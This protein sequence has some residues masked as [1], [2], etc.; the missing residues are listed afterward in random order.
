MIWIHFVVGDPFLHS[1]SRD[2]ETE[3]LTIKTGEFS[4]HKKPS[5]G[6]CDPH[7]LWPA[8]HVLGGKLTRASLKNTSL[9]LH[10]DGLYK[11][12]CNKS[13]NWTV[14]SDRFRHALQ[15]IS[16][17]GCAKQI[18]FADK[19]GVQLTCNQSVTLYVNWKQNYL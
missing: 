5:N 7:V 19:L 8:I 13:G 10:A 14:L 9:G 1:V 15:V 4:L 2:V 3:K 11:F 17:A 18:K 16:T 6:T 12:S